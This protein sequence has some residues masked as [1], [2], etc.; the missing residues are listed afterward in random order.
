MFTNILF[1]HFIAACIFLIYILI[2][3]FYIRFFVCKKKSESFYKL[4]LKPMLTLC[5][6]LFFSGVYLFFNSSFSFFLGLK[7]LLAL[8]L[9]FTFFYCPFFMKRY[10]NM[11]V[12]VFFRVTVFS[13]LLA[14][15]FLGFY[16]I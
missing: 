2:D 8:M 15:M 3:R 12:R 7:A 14:V 13:L 16:I 11:Y 4:I 1:M 9:I 5:F 6:I 10:K